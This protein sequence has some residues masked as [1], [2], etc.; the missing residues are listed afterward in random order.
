LIQ[1]AGVDYAV[2]CTFH[3]L[4]F[5]FKFSSHKSPEPKLQFSNLLKPVEASNHSW[6]MLLVCLWSC[7][8]LSIVAGFDVFLI[9][10]TAVAA[11]AAAAA[12]ADYWWLIRSDPTQ[13]FIS[14]WLK[15]DTDNSVLNILLRGTV[16]ASAYNAV[17]WTH[18]RN[19]FGGLW[20]NADKRC[21]CK[22]K[23]I[24][25]TTRWHMLLHL[26]CCL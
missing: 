4:E 22:Y 9:R 15:D 2:G 25:F 8:F 16:L 3:A 23:P 24:D 12:A 26:V 10:A 5:S 7:F 19:E 20:T 1:V 18:F 13:D 6:L 17:V 14:A 11:A 21:R